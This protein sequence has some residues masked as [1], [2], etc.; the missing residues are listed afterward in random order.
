MQ[1]EQFAQCF[2]LAT[3]SVRIIGLNAACGRCCS[4]R[5]QRFSNSAVSA[6]KSSSVSDLVANQS[7]TSSVRPSESPRPSTSSSSVL[8]S[9]SPLTQAISLLSAHGECQPQLSLSSSMSQTESAV[10]E[11]DL[12]SAAEADV[13]QFQ[14]PD[15]SARALTSGDLQPHDPGTWPA[16]LASSAIDFILAAGPL[17]REDHFAAYN[18]PKTNGRSFPKAAFVKK[19]E[20]DTSLPRSWL[21]YSETTDTAY[22]SC[23]AI[24]K[25]N[26]CGALSS[27]GTRDWHHVSK[28]LDSHPRSHPRISA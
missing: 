19:M 9:T 24:F 20:N 6:S 2:S 16:S 1:I 8:P 10:S 3:E 21:I 17:P 18:F 28:I 15:Q 12:D 4:R 13:S 25:R 7:P 5:C 14:F 22:C 26:Q 23:C 11:V 27:V